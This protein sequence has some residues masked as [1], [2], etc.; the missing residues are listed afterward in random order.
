MGPSPWLWNLCEVS[1]KSL[2]P[3]LVYS[4]S[5]TMIPLHITIVT[6]GPRL[7]AGCRDSAGTRWCSQKYN[8]VI[9]AEK[10]HTD[11]LSLICLY[12]GTVAQWSLVSAR[13]VRESFGALKTFEFFGPFLYY[14]KLRAKK[15]FSIKNNVSQLKLSLKENELFLFI[16]YWSPLSSI[17]SWQTQDDCKTFLNPLITDGRPEIWTLW[18]WEQL[19]FSVLYQ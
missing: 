12:H 4:Y 15:C 1:F 8:K 2:V 11:A 14:F 3:N 18:P 13:T 6:S 5:M 10:L 7:A 17:F 16:S 9:C 19:F